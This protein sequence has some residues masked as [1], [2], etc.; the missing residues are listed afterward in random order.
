MATR[1]IAARISGLY[2]VLLAAYGRRGWWPITSLAGRAGFDARG[3]HPGDYD[4]P[5]SARARFEIAV[6]AILTQ[7]TAWTNAESALARLRAAGVGLP[8]DVN[9]LPPEHLAR[10]IGPAGYF[11][12]KARKLGGIARLFARPGALTLRGAPSREKLLEQWGIGPETADSIL[13]YAFRVPVFVIDA[14]TRRTFGRIGLIDADEGY[15][16]IQSRLLAAL[17]ADHALY[18]EYHAL[19]V[20]HAKRHCRSKPLC[21]GCPVRPCRYRAHGRPSLPA[22]ALYS[23]RGRPPSRRASAPAG[24]GLPPSAPLRGAT[25]PLPR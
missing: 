9:A 17:P 21:E 13:L 19:I 2:E 14:Y 11:N 16:G 10:L 25:H 5:L 3:Y 20:E 12:Q 24:Q 7:N 18:N 6:G 4:Q 22:R 1:T 8:D 15:A 23:V